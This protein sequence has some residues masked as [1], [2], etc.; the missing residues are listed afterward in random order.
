[1][2]NKFYS[3]SVDMP[4]G[5]SPD[6]QPR[7]AHAADD[8]QLD[9]LAYLNAD[10]RDTTAANGKVS[11]TIEEAASQLL[12]G[13]PGWGSM[14]QPFTVTYAYRAN[15]PP[16]MPSDADGFSR[17]NPAQ[18]NQAELAFTAWSDVAN[19]RFS[20]IGFGNSGEAAYSN[21]ATI[22][23][24]NYSS[25]V[26]GASAFSFYPGSTGATSSAGDV[27]VNS[28]FAFNTNPSVG[29]YGGTVLVHEIGHTIGLA[30]PSDY[31]AGDSASP[32]YAADAGYYEDDRQYTVM[33]YFSETNTGANFG[34]AYSAAP[35]LDDIAAAQ[36]AYGANMATRT[37]DTVYGFG[38]T[39]DRPWFVATASTSKLV[40]A[41]WDAGGTDTFNFSG[42]GFNQLIDLRPG[43]FSNVGGLVGNVAVAENVV[44]EN[45]VG[46]SG[47]DVIHGN[48]AG[49]TIDGGA[50][51][52]RIDGGTRGSNR[53]FG[54]DGDDVIVGGADFDAVNGNKGEDTIDGGAG[55]NDW[56][57]G[58]QGDD[59]IVAHAGNVILNGNI[60]AD[61]VLGGA[62]ADLV[63]GGQGND[64]L[65]GGGGDDQIFGDLGADTMTGG[66]G[67]DIFHFALGGGVDVVADFNL[68]DGDRIQLDG[69]PAY[70]VAQ[71]GSDTVISIGV[72]ADQLVLIGVQA[73]T[74][75]PGSI[76]LA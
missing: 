71:S 44:I 42:Y 19:I 50:G 18:I 7:W 14:G 22:S 30:H 70:A 61:A 33:S 76:L 60:G 27:W 59:Q 20:R 26:D 67:A 40:F 53:L 75:G 62:G 41:V 45:A 31:D 2:L 72:G 49:N 51:A 54:G 39:A 8:F 9:P 43:F 21:N 24:G 1:M 47:A 3:L 16:T 73:A 13:E 69:A 34:G 28:T 65:N 38:A 6:L 12:R 68:A 64:L 37:G 15:A 17:F 35:L 57:L 4:S 23:L 25:G 11:F 48:D 58:G 55:G 32:N 56:L 63:R 46:G 36:M 74:L 10:A 5:A 66:P 52:D 29:A